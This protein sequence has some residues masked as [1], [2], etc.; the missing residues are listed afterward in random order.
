MEPSAGVIPSLV[1]FS[2]TPHHDQR[3]FF[4]RT[5][6]AV[7]AEREGVD[8]TVF[9]EDSLSRS[10]QVVVSGL[11]VRVGAGE[12]RTVRCSATAIFDVA[13]DL[14]PG[15]PTYRRGLSFDLDGTS[16]RSIYAPPGSAHGFQALTD[17]ADTSCRINRL[18][19]PTED[20]T[21]ALDDATL[22]IRWPLPMTALSDHDRTVR[23]LVELSPELSRI[24]AIA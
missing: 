18:C 23:P 2:T 13:V 16:Q 5:F 14:R 8:H 10:K 1:L 22:A 11:H 7:V 24:D 20:L 12:G 4:S 21:I 3:G 19:D 6:D 17:T 9:V 15:S